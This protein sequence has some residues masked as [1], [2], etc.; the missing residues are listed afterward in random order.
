M[1]LGLNIILDYIDIYL[2]FYY[3]YNLA[4]LGSKKKNLFLFYLSKSM[5][6]HV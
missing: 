4:C 2:D 3:N 6:Q 5:S 1:Y